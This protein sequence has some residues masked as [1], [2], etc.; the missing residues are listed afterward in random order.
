[1]ETDTITHWI[2]AAITFL[3]ALALIYVIF[4]QLPT[5]VGEIRGAVLDSIPEELKSMRD[6]VRS[7][8]ETQSAQLFPTKEQTLAILEPGI[9]R[10]KFNMLHKLP[11]IVEQ[12]RDQSDDTIRKI[13][14]HTVWDG[15]N[16][17]RDRWDKFYDKNLGNLRVA[18][19]DKMIAVRK[20]SIEEA[21]KIILSKNIDDERK[22]EELRLITERAAHK[23]MQEVLQVFGL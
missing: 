20:E 7:L 14:E 6:E 18:F 10:S 16:Y 11:D 19:K 9:E 4:W 15:L 1:M 21:L 22:K 12:T 2:P 5:Q 13:L 8:K 17:T 23:A 3:N